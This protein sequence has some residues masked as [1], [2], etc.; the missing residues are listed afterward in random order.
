[1]ATSNSLSQP[2]TSSQTFVLMSSTCDF[3]Q[4]GICQIDS[5]FIQYS[6]AADH[7]LQSCIRGVAS[8]TP[9]THA[10]GA[11]VT[12]IEALPGTSESNAT[13]ILSSPSVISVPNVD[14]ADIISI[15]TVITDS[16]TLTLPNPSNLTPGR[17]LAV[18]HKFTGTGSLS[19][20]GVSLSAGSVHHFVWDGFTWLT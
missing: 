5:E 7:S 4:H 6:F 11:I 20:N 13:L 2:M 19:V 8:S 15:N 10:E 12:F 9:V 17:D 1:M 3:P 18:G 14:N 16:L